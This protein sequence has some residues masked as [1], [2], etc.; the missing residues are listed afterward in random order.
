MSIKQGKV[1]SR[2]FGM[3]SH[4]R[5]T[6]AFSVSTFIITIAQTFRVVRSYDISPQHTSRTEFRN[7][8][9]VIGTDTEIEFD[10]LCYYGRRNPGIRQLI[11]V[12]ITPS[13]RITQFLR[14]VS[15]CVVQ[16]D[17]IY[18]QYPIERKW[19]DSF[20]QGFGCLNHIP[21]FFTTGQHLVK[22]V[23]I[24]RA[25]QLFHI[26]ILLLEISYQQISQLNNVSL[27]GREVKFYTLSLNI[28]QQCFNVFCIEF[29]CFYM[30]RKRINSFVEDIQ[31]F[32]IGFLRTFYLDF[33]TNQPL[34]IVFL[35]TSQIGKFSGKRV[36]CL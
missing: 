7:F 31:R 24:D 21:L 26:I 3:N 5:S 33:L 34:I 32:R 28:I 18:I 10:F 29:F 8:E 16:W 27:T 12:F 9:E 19:L 25:F 23:I 2:G 13:Q 15:S 20:D 11:H 35:G 30:E 22:E 14:N 17:C 6:T 4:L 1:E 36:C